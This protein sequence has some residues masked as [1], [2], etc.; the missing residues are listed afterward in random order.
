MEQKILFHTLAEA[1]IYSSLPE[2]FHW[3][4]KQIY[5]EEFKRFPESLFSKHLK[6]SLPYFNENG[7]LHYRP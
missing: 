3:D 7:L 6:Y 4:L 2:T 1:F 5:K